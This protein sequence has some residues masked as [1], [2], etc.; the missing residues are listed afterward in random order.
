MPATYIFRQPR[1][2]F[3]AGGGHYDAD[4]SLKIKINNPFGFLEPKVNF[5]T[6]HSNGYLYSFIRYP[7]P[8]TW[9]IGASYDSFDDDLIGDTQ[10]FNPK[11]GATF[12]VTSDTT[13]RLAYFKV[14]KRTLFAD[15]T[16]EPT[17]VAGFNQLF[18]DFNGTKSTRYGAAVDHAFSPNFYGGLEYSI[19]RLRVPTSDLQANVLREDWD[20]NLY[21]AYLY[22]TIYRDLALSVEYQY[23]DFD[24]D[25]K[26]DSLATP[27]HMKTHWLPV[28]LRYFHPTGLFGGLKTTYVN[29]KVKSA[30]VDNEDSEFALVD[31]AVGYRLPKRYGVLSFEVGNLFDKDFNFQG[32]D[33]RTSEETA[34]N[35]Q[36][37]PE[38]TAVLRLT[39]AF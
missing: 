28:T 18:D 37:F 27:S 8:V 33:S 36:F 38:R 9:T 12:D 25:V 34:I 10:R 17:Q 5:D 11:L 30:T 15:Q 29:Q 1:F 4:N 6:E 14:L 35:P 13:L 24:R 31:V 21:R 20:E 2:S 32:L 7:F 3:I 16:L 19:R 26:R 23:E 22:W 39:L